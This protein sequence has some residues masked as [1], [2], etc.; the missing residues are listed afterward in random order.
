M[1]K[2]ESA[3]SVLSRGQLETNEKK[4]EKIPESDSNSLLYAAND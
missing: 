4:R 1:N 2:T 3:K